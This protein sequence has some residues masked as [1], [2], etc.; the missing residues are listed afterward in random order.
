MTA[1]KEAQAQ[2]VNAYREM[3]RAMLEGRTD[4]LD[5]L[6]DDQYSLTHITGYRQP[7][8]EWLAAIESGEMRYH[9]A[10]ERSVTVDVTGNRAVLVGRSAVTATIYGAHGTWNLQL[11]TDYE[12][13]DRTW[14]TTRT[15]ATT[16]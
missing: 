5:L 14:I 1:S 10:E 7:K 13:K 15:V 4:R 11:T 16:F 8:R 2:S 6:L 3:Y 9:A 12:R